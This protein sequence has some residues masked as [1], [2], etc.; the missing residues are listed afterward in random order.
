M[1]RFGDISLGHGDLLK[2]VEFWEA[3]RPLFE[4]SSQAKQVQNIN[5]RLAGIDEDVLEQHRKNLARLA[6]LNVPTGT[7]EELEDDL[8]DI[9]D[10]DKVD[11]NDEKELD[12]I[13]A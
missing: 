6:E 11:I 12:L 5:E 8:S 1:L 10:L 9:D 13:A 2:A 3:A 7:V 4:R